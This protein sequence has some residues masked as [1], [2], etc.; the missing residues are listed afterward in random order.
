MSHN[1][2]TV[3]HL[4]PPV[5]HSTSNSVSSTY[6]RSS[7][8]NHSE[9][10]SSKGSDNIFGFDIYGSDFGAFPSAS[11]RQHAPD[12][13]A[14]KKKPVVVVPPH[15]RES[16]MPILQ[17]SAMTAFIASP[18]SSR[19][20]DL[21]RTM[22][23][24]NRINGWGF[25]SLHDDIDKMVDDCRARNIEETDK[26]DA[27]DLEKTHSSETDAT[28]S[29]GSRE[30]SPNSCWSSG[31][32]STPSDET[33][34]FDAKFPDEE[35]HPEVTTQ[36]HK[37]QTRV[38]YPIKLAMIQF[39]RDPSPNAW[40][41]LVHSLREEKVRDASANE[42]KTFQDEI[43]DAMIAPSSS[44]DSQSG[45]ATF[46]DVSIAN[47][48]DVV[49]EHDYKSQQ[50]CAMDA[51]L[52]R[53]SHDRW[54]ELVQSIRQERSREPELTCPTLLRLESKLEKLEEEASAAETESKESSSIGRST[55]PRGGVHWQ[56]FKHMGW[57]KGARTERNRQVSQVVKIDGYD[58]AKH[59]A[60]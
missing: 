8:S 60:V 55:T 19:W 1:F 52:E 34:T 26:Y 58:E 39:V 29:S 25:T 27:V 31:E 33:F 5:H 43:A 21:V 37:A 50:K 35:M 41:E 3:V 49:V 45:W 44:Y 56:R 59:Y 42:E 57:V 53:P 32:E 16:T 22:R 18:S 13:G 2:G 4:A 24:E 6:S 54:T 38:S 47:E 40:A 17:K 23:V 12:H 7:S 15:K 36:E 20:S 14:W 10:S 48:Q 9:T 46:D 11:L 51:F 28:T 30:D